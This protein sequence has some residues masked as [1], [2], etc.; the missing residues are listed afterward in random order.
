[1]ANFTLREYLQK[2]EDA[3]SSGHIEDA[4]TNCQHLLSNFPDALEAQR[5]LGEIYLAKGQLEEAQQTFDWI[6]VNDP[7]NVITYCDRALTSER[8][9]DIDTAL[10]CYQQ[11]YELSR[12]NSQIRQE[13]NQLSAKVGQPR[14]MFSRAGLARLYMRG[15]LLLQAIQEWETV[16]T[17]TPDRLDARIGLLEALWR[18]GLNE[19]V[20]QLAKQILSEIPTCLKA[21]L[22]LAYTTSTH[23]ISQARELIRQA[24]ALDPELIMANELFSDLLAREPNDPFLVLIKKEPIIVPEIT[25]RPLAT[26]MS[27]D[28]ET[29]NSTKAKST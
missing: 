23:N 27:A 11:A 26:T 12:G 7:E 25:H 1:M 17:V 4:M 19:R 6:L 8:Q 3:I 2:T 21:L 18:E 29:T 24:E 10:D 16:L 9:S 15:D 22:L 28:S 20:E 5:L 13:F 14:F